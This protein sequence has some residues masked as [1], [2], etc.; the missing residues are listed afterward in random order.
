VSATP[1]YFAI[2]GTVKNAPA[3]VNIASATVQVKKGSLIVKTLYT[4][5]DGTFSTGSTLKPGTYDLVVARA[6]YTFTLPAA[7]L[8]IGPSSTANM[9]LAATPPSLTQPSTGKSPMIIQ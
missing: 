5:A 2:G 8:I 3:T 1:A 6:G 9:I 7:T 4:A